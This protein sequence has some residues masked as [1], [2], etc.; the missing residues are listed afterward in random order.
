MMVSL[1]K[2]QSN[3]YKLWDSNKNAF[4]KNVQF[5]ITNGMMD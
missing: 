3:L 1:Q 2:T 5:S 4:N